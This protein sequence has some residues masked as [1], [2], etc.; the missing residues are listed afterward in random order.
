MKIVPLKHVHVGDKLASDLRDSNGRLIL[1]RG[2]LLTPALIDLLNNAEVADI[3]VEI[4][5]EDA[6][7]IVK[8]R[9]AEL[10]HRFAGHEECP[11]MSAIKK[12]VE[13]A[14]QKGMGKPE[15]E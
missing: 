15:T 9:L 2:T 13:A 7:E 14:I 1:A 3:A 6:G 11:Y 12:S 10:E 4:Q 8:R 5:D